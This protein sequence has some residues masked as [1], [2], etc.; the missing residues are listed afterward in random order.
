MAHTAVAQPYAKPVGVNRLYIWSWADFN[1]VAF[2]S[3]AALCILNVN[4]LMRLVFDAPRAASLFILLTAI[5]CILTA[6]VPLSRAMGNLGVSFFIFLSYFLMVATLQA[7]DDEK[8]FGLFQ[9]YGAVF[10]ITMATMAVGW[11]QAQREKLETVLILFYLIWLISVCSIFFSSSLRQ[12]STDFGTE[13]RDSGFFTNPNHAGAVTGITFAIGFALLRS[14]RYTLLLTIGL[15]ITSVGTLR[16]FSKMA[17]LTIF[18]VAMFQILG[19]K[20]QRNR[21]KVILLA[22]VALGSLYLLLVYGLEQLD[23]NAAQL[24]RLLEVRDILMNQ[25]INDETTTSRTYLV[26]V[27]FRKFLEHPLLGQGLGSFHAMPEAMGLGTHNTYLLVAGESGI[28][29]LI[30]MLVFMFR[31]LKAALA[32]DYLM[33]RQFCVNFI[34]V[35]STAGL[36]SHDMLTFR[37]ENL[38]MGFTI[39]LLVGRAAYRRRKDEEE[40]VRL[41][42]QTQEGLIEA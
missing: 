4:A 41:A 27:G 17:I 21:I 12:I 16:T 6:R 24:V 25:E 42:A 5:A 40:R 18:T 1:L 14:G 15:I 8:L 38:M 39:G 32:C 10:V 31:W 13:N 30:L 2:F 37:F 3:L 20:N 36:S 35:F 19:G 29:A 26:Q 11:R 23:L 7:L 9:Q 34:L 22:L 33:L 28:F